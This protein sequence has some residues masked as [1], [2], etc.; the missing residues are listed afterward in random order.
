[1]TRSLMT[2]IIFLFAIILCA[3]SA[4][5]ADRSRLRFTPAGTGE[6]TFDTGLLSGKLRA[7][8]KSVGLLPVVHIPS[9]ATLTR[10]MGFAG[11]YRVF[12]TNKRYGP[13]AWYWPSEAKLAGD[14][15]VE[16]HWSADAER[17]FD[18]WAVYRWVAPG[19]LDVETRVLSSTDILD[20]EVFEAQYFSEGFSES[21]VYA[22]GGPE[23]KPAFIPAEQSAGVWQMFPRDGEAVK[24]IRDGRWKIPPS[25]VD[26]V[27]RPVLEQPVG[28]RRHRGSGLAIVMMA[29][30]EDCFAVS[31]PHQAEGHYSMYFSLFG[32]TLKA[33]EPARARV[34]IM[35]M[36]APTDKEVLDAYKAYLRELRGRR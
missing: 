12:S 28:I 29:P 4:A 14:G 7:E 2:T 25:P 36:T 32:R 23:G 35:L 16:T 34:R 18:M 33:G 31:T 19:T 6:F 15:S 20:F 21:L 26:W 8:G 10:S 24:M 13:G 3:S 11:H 5:P 1:M 17:P 9:G 30:P 27:I 22:R